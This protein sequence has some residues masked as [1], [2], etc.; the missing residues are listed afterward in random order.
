MAGKLQPTTLVMAMQ[1][2]LRYSG[3]IKKPL[4][5]LITGYP[6]LIWIPKEIF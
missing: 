5:M 6:I 3:E 2:V 4:R 1:K